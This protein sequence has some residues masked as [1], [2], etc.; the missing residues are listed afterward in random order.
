[1]LADVDRLAR[2]VEAILVLSRP[3]SRS[4]PEGVVNVADLARE[5][6]GPDTEVDA[7]DEALVDADARLVEL[8]LINLLENAAKFSGH[9]ARRV[10]ISRDAGAVRIAVVD[11]GPGVPEALLARMFDR[12]WR[13]AADGSGSG[14]G[15]ALV[16][17]VAERS[18]GCAEA[19]P[20]P[21]GVGLEVSITFGRVLGWHEAR[22][23]VVASSRR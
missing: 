6:A 18:G 14:L 23:D 2:V 1:M 4:V 21:D 8:A 16:R 13:G 7:P 15:L 17:A 5:L 10:R 22:H 3:N 11:D 20:N 9:A 19:K 12:Y